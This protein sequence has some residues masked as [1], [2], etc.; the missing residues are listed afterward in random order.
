MLHPHGTP[1]PAPHASDYW[2]FA[3]LGPL[4]FLARVIETFLPQLP[5]MWLKFTRDEH[6]AKLLASCGNNPRERARGFIQNSLV[7]GHIM[8]PSYRPGYS[9]CDRVVAF[10]Y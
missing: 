6:A 5:E 4:R 8:D 3:T 1:V 2:I 7:D 9:W 10:S